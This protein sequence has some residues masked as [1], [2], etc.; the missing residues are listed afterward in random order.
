MMMPDGREGQS[1][2]RIFPV[3]FFFFFSDCKAL[4][5][6]DIMIFSTTMGY[7]EFIITGTRE[8]TYIFFYLLFLMFQHYWDHALHIL[9]RPIIIDLYAIIFFILIFTSVQ[10]FFTS[11]ILSLIFF[12]TMYSVLYF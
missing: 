8:V 5:Q 11:R 4:W 2:I 10:Y 6:P 7:G 12:N 9:L 3:I 1:V